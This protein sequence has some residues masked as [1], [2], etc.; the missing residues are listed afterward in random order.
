MQVTVYHRDNFDPRESSGFSRVAVVNAP[1]DDI[2]QALEYA[3][4]YTQNIHGSWSFGP[5]FEGTQWEGEVNHDANTNVQFVG[6]HPIAK[7]GRKLGAR[8]T[9][10]RDVMYCNG[11]KYEVASFGFDKVA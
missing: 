6:N 2:D 1:C 4:H 5:K 3:F 9:S 7:D 8:S 11:S 10:V